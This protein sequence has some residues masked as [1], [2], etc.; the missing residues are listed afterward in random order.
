M[1]LAGHNLMVPFSYWNPNSFS[2]FTLT[3]LSLLMP[4]G[5]VYFPLIRFVDYFGISQLSEIV[6]L[7]V[8]L[9]TMC[10][11]FA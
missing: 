2:H 7:G 11:L 3:M 9:L 8:I 10:K 1:A 6:V 5:T 4:N